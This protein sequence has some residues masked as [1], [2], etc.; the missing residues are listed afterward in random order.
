MADEG[1][2]SAK[3]V[4]KLKLAAEKKKRKEKRREALRHGMDGRGRGEVWDEEWVQKLSLNNGR[5]M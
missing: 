5:E 4:N 1:S 3:N 2:P